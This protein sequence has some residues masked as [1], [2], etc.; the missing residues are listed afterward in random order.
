MT[1][2]KTRSKTARKPRKSTAKAVATY[3]DL[4]TTCVRPSKYIGSIDKSLTKLITSNDE[5]IDLWSFAGEP[6]D[7]PI[8]KRVYVVRKTQPDGKVFYNLQ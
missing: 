1:N 6:H 7:I 5:I 3:T 2:V 8:G 4:L